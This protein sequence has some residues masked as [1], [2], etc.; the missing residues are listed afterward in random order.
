MLPREIIGHLVVM[1]D[2]SIRPARGY[3]PSLGLGVV[4]TADV[5][6]DIATRVAHVAYAPLWGCSSTKVGVL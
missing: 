5:V 2:L 4:G 1:P 6:P 3:R